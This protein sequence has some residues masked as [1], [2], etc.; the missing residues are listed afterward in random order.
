MKIVTK[1]DIGLDPEMIDIPKGTIGRIIR[2]YDNNRKYDVILDGFEKYGEIVLWK[3][4]FDI[5]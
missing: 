2:S 4:D 5:L 3:S 1:L